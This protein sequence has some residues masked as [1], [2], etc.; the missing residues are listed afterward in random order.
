M[1]NIAGMQHHGR[2]GG[3]VRAVGIM[4][5]L[6]AEAVALLIHM[7]AL[8]GHA[9]EMVAGV[10]LHAGLGRQ[11]RHDA[12]ALRLANFR[13]KTQAAAKKR[14]AVPAKVKKV[15]KKVTKKVAARSRKVA[16]K[17]T[18]SAPKAARRSAAKK[19]PARLAKKR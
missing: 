3:L 5:C 13:G 2:E 7:A 16:K 4:L 11:H 15:A 18:K 17:A 8:A 12:T 19:A 6:K 1:I 9:F 10:K 14:G